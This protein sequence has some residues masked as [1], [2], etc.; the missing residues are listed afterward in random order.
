[1]ISLHP[2]AY[3]ERLRDIGLNAH[4]AELYDAYSSGVAPQVV[5]MRRVLHDHR[6]KARE[7]VWLKGR[8]NGEL[9]EVRC[10]WVTGRGR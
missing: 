9:D 6:E 4:D 2:Q 3:A 8:P 10:R 5:R 7:R 1:M